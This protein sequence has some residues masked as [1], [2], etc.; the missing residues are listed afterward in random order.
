[1]ALVIMG[2]SRVYAQIEID[3][4]DMA[5]DGDGFIYAVKTYRVGE[6]NL[7]DLNRGGWDVSD[8]VPDT[9]DTVRY[10]SK[11]RSKYG[12]LFPN[13]ELVKFQT[14]KNMEFL[15]MDSSKVRMQ[16]LINDYLGLKATVVIVFPTDMVLYK[17][18]LKQGSYISYFYIAIEHLFLT[19]IG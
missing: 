15:T 16:G 3:Y 17:F 10:Y 19:G 11:R 4:T 1:M 5:K 12:K 18:P 8:I 13:S 2:V 7:Q 6:L 9:Y 14:K